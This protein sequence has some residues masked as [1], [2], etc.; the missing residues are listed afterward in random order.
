MQITSVDLLLIITCSFVSVQAPEPAV[1]VTVEYESSGRR[2]DTHLPGGSQGR[3]GAA[4]AAQSRVL[5]PVRGALRRPLES[6]T[7][8]TVNCDISFCGLYI[9]LQYFCV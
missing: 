9:S 2:L 8:T 1:E 6:D 3:V 4:A 7:L 5:R